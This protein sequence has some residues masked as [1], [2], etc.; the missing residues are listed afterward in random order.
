MAYSERA[1]ERLERAVKAAYKRN[2]NAGQTILIVA[3]GI[4]YRV[5][6]DLS[7]TAIKSV[8]K[9]FKIPKGTKIKLD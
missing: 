7:R 5:Q 1:V 2:L 3:N 4:L 9:R 8:P 6:S